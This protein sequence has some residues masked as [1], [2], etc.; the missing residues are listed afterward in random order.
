MFDAMKLKFW[1][2]H[3]KQFRLAGPAASRAR[4]RKLLEQSS[5]ASWW[6]SAGKMAAAILSILALLGLVIQF[7]LPLTRIEVS[8]VPGSWKKMASLNSAGGTQYEFTM[9]LRNY[10]NRSIIMT[11]QE[12]K[13]LRICSNTPLR[14]G[15]SPPIVRIVGNTSL[16]PGRVDVASM[17]DNILQFGRVNFWVPLVSGGRV[18]VRIESPVEDLG[19]VAILPIDQVFFIPEHLR[20]PSGRCPNASKSPGE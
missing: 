19:G 20:S 18:S 17:G 12:W 6:E 16:D 1:Q 13:L 5:P 15:Q 2:P 9:A 14:P 3:R 4:S 8:V 11:E 7:V 10:G